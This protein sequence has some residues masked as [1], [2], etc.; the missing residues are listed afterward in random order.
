VLSTSVDRRVHRQQHDRHRIDQ[1][2][3]SGGIFNNGLIDPRTGIAASNVATYSGGITNAAA[4][5]IT[6]TA[7]GIK[8]SAVTAFSG[9]IANAGT[10]T[11]PTGIKISGSTIT[12]AIVDSG[13]IL[14]TNHGIAI[15][16][17]SQITSTATAIKIAGPTFTGGISN[18]GTV[19][20][21]VGIL[22]SG[23]VASFAGAIVNGGNITG[24]GGTAIDLSA[25]PNAITIDQNGGTVTGAVKLSAHAD[26]ILTTSV[27][28]PSPFDAL[29]S[30]VA[31]VEAIIAALVDRLGVAPLARMARYDALFAGTV[32]AAEEG[33]I[34]LENT[35]E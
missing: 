20:G 18:A 27:A 30:A 22:V 12:G 13:T 25:A 15:D 32:D 5:V 1:R 34:H 11:A 10:I 3:F 31:L 21:L 14:A 19:S 24:S 35:G 4:G 8:V 6:A 9:N 2:N 26:V 16:G 29:T 17:T 23:A 33:P 7:I 28:S